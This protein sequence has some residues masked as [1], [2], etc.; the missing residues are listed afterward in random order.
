MFGIPEWAIGVGFIMLVISL[1][2]VLVGPAGAR[3][4]LRGRAGRELGPTLEEMERR[5]G[6]LEEGQRRLSENDDA[7]TRLSEIEERLDFVERMLAKQRD[8]ERIVPPKS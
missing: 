3:Q 2:K 4:R 5:L 8:A 1:G 6:E 7:Q